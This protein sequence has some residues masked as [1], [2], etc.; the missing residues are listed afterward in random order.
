MKI[1]NENEYFETFDLSLAASL[2]AMGFPLEAV[3]KTSSKR[4]S[5]IYL[6]S[7]QLDEAVF[8]YRR[9]GVRLEPETFFLQLKSLKSKIYEKID[10]DDHRG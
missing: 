8:S 1:L 7:P 10:V 5:F 6:R 9:G 4:V 3:D 2:R